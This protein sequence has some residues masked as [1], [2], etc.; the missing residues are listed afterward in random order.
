MI[1]TFLQWWVGNFSELLKIV[2]CLI[3]VI[4]QSQIGPFNFTKALE[5]YY[6]YEKNVL[7]IN[8]VD[9]KICFVANIVICCLV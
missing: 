6:I 9:Y 8:D 4:C 7:L 2:S 3:C 1:N 5:Y